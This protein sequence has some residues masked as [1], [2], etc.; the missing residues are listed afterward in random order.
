M[1]LTLAMQKKRG[2]CYCTHMIW[3]S[4]KPYRPRQCPFD[5][6]PYHQLDGYKSYTQYLKDTGAS[7]MAQLLKTAGLKRL[8]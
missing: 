6:C 8:G 7:N 4:K 5:E 1:K 3:G 2:C